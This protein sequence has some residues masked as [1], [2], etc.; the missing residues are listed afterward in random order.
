M[1]STPVALLAHSAT[2]QKQARFNQQTGVA[3]NHFA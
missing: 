1:A 3:E 2:R